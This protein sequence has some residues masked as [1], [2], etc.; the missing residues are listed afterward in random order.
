MS[1]DTWVLLAYFVFIAAL[2]SG[3]AYL[4]YRKDV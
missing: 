3:F 4:S 2:Y 1:A